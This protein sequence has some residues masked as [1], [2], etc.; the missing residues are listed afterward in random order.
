M[1]YRTALITG[2][3]SGIGADLARRLAARG[4]EVALVARRED[5]LAELADEIRSAGGRARCYPLDV[6]DPDA[7]T[8][9]IQ[10]ADDELDGLDLVV[11]NA[12]I[13]HGRWSGKLTWA[14]CAPVIAVNV[15]G[16]VATLT[17]VLPRMAKRKRGHLVGMSS[18]AAFRGI[19][20]MAAYCGSKAFLSNFLESLRI[21]LRKTGVAVTE[22]R[23]GFVKTPLLSD[24]DRLPPFTIELEDAGARI[25]RAI[26]GRRAVV[27]F[28]FP[29]AVG[30]RAA[31]VLPAPIYAWLRGG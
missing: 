11:A 17:A 27:T 28:P 4:V 7:T 31:S 30:M 21:D 13:G 8:R 25:L 10:G 22:I 19:P 20:K 29:V 3:S 16:A 5:A 12:G 2:A 18:I 1:Q 6:T 14:D 9:V 24:F 15:V 23:P 26:E